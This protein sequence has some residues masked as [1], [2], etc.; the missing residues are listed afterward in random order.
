MIIAECPL[1]TF[2][3]QTRLNPTFA[4]YEQVLTALGK[5][6]DAEQHLWVLFMDLATEVKEDGTNERSKALQ[7]TGTLEFM[8]IEVL[9]MALPEARHDLNHTYRHDLESFFY[10]FLHVC[11]SY[12][13]PDGNK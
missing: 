8:A 7:M 5:L 10:V 4:S 9:E 11:I 13:W 2:G 1:R 3:P 12:G 6:Q